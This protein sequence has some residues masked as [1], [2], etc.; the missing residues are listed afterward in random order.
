MKALPLALSLLI[1]AAAFAQGKF[2]KAAA[3]G[4]DL[5]ATFQTSEGSFVVRLF[6]KDAPKTVA[7]FVGLATGEKEWTDPKSG[8]KKKGAALY[9]N[10]ICHRIIAG[11]MIQ[12]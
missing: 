4:K 8:E 9:S 3:E 2:M 10:T 5:Y 6:S 7:N 1:P 11:F 12:C